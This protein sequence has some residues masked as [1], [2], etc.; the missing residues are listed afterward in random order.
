MKKR[1]AAYTAGKKETAEQMQ[2]TEMEL[3]SLYFLKLEDYEKSQDSI[4]RRRVPEQRRKIKRVG[5]PQGSAA[6]SRLPC[7]EDTSG[8][9]TKTGS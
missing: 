1:L 5:S 7:R 6:V 2:T 8:G 4:S 3:G 9:R